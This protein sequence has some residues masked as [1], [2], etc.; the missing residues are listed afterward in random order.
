[1]VMRRAGTGMA[2][3]NNVDV[4]ASDD[5][6]P[7]APDGGDIASTVDVNNDDVASEDVASESVAE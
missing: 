2:C 4:L 5:T 1:M 7:T 3:Y 6:D